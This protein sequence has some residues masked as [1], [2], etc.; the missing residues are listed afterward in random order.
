MRGRRDFSWINKAQR[1][2]DVVGKLAAQGIEIRTETPEA[3]QAF[4]AGRIDIRAKVKE[5]AIKAD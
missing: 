2:P 1:D 4:I 3:A 5:N